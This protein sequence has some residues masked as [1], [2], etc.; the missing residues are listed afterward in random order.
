[1]L[2]LGKVH[3]VRPRRGPARRLVHMYAAFAEIA[4]IQVIAGNSTA[5]SRATRSA[6]NA[7][8]LVPMR[9]PW[10][11]AAHPGHDFGAAGEVEL[12]QDVADMGLDCSLRQEQSRGDLAVG[13]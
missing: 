13:Q 5:V 6:T 7:H 2:R 1:M 4:S 11:A 8:L 10:S 12:G 9:W 3:R